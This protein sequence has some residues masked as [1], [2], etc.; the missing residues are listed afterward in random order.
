MNQ[1]PAALLVLAAAGLS[2]AAHAT[3]MTSHAQAS[4]VL[5]LCAVAVGVWGVVSLVVA[6]ARERELLIDGHARLDVLDRVGVRE[7]VRALKEVVRPTPTPTPTPAPAPTPPR[8]DRYPLEISVDTQS[9]LNA[10]ARLEGRDRSELLDEL[11]RKHLPELE[12]TRVA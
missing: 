2:H 11:I 7:P 1:T 8:V 3:S 5:T 9:R 4:L 10:V 6:C 12:E